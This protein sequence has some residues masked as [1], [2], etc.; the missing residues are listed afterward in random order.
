MGKNPEKIYEMVQD[1]VGK[2]G[3]PVS[4]AGKDGGRCILCM[5]IEEGR[6]K[7]RTG[8]CAAEAERCEAESKNI[9]PLVIGRK[10]W[11]FS[12]TK[13][14][15]GHV[16][17]HGDGAPQRTQPRRLSSVPVPQASVCRKEGF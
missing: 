5:E 13:K 10:A 3:I 17:H 4:R 6:G 11:L 14:G 16:H 15:D 1:E 2:K 9:K 7:R 8:I 12:N